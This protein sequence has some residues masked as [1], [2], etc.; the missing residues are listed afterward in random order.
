MNKSLDRMPLEKG[1]KREERSFWA[2]FFPH[3]KA[4]AFL[5]CALLLGIASG[6][7][8]AVF[9][10]LL[11][12]RWML[13]LRFSGIPSPESGFFSCFST[14]LLNALIGLI[15]LFLLG[16]TAFGV[17]AV[18]LFLFFRGAC[19]GI[20]VSYFLLGDEPW[21]LLRS[22]L[23]YTP[24]SAAVGVLLLLFG[25]RSLIF[26][27]HL[28]KVSFFSREGSLDLRLYF[29]DFLMF[30]SLI[31]AVSLAGSVPAAVYGLFL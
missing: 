23:I 24:A 14:L 1:A 12:G 20:G 18:P 11:Q 25:V 15:P 8:L 17:F 21:G 26:S 7:V 4:I 29:H 22:A 10:P 28:A 3:R 19:V 6:S 13:P 27:A 30:V 9:S 2:R 5:L 16:V 31:V